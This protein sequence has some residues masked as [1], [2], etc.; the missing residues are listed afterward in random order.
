MNRKGAIHDASMHFKI[1]PRTVE[2]ALQR[3]A[4]LL[5]EQEEFEATR[6]LGSDA[7]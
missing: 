3:L 6:A 4:I 2:T 1:S 5:A 7:K